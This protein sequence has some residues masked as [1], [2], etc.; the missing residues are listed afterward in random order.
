[1]SGVKQI[2]AAQARNLAVKCSRIASMPEVGIFWLIDNKLVA[3]SIPW[4]QGDVYGGFYNGKN[5]H[6]TFWATLQRIVPQ[7]KGADYTDHPRGRVLYHSMNETFL[8]Y[9]SQAVVNNPPMRKLD[10]RGVQTAIGGN[11][12]RGGL[13]LRERNTC[14]ARPGL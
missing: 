9:S 10:F 11:E 2:E 4:R 13:S 1:M 5:D 8:V 12:I 7:W 3:N 14:R 6:A